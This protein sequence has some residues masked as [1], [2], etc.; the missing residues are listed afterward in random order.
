M[1]CRRLKDNIKIGLKEVGYDTLN[2]PGL[3]GTNGGLDHVKKVKKLR[4]ATNISNKYPVTNFSIKESAVWGSCRYLIIYN[5]HTLKFLKCT[6]GE[7]GY[8]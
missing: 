5:V 6:A 8:I 7:N 1:P 2:S 4:M 3:E